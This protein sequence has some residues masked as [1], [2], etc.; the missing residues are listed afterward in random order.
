MNL[1]QISLSDITSNQ[2]NSRQPVPK[3]QRQGY[4]V[5][6][7]V[8]GV[9]KPTLFALAL[10]NQ[11]QKQT[12][13]ALIDAH[14]PDIARMAASLGEDEQLQNIMV[15]PLGDKFALVFGANRCLATLYLHAK[16]NGK[17]AA[18]LW[19]NR[20]EIDQEKA[21]RLSLQENARRRQITYLDEARQC[22]LLAKKGLTHEQIT[23]ELW[24]KHVS[25]ATVANRLKLLK[26]SPKDTDRMVNGEL[27]QESALRI[28]DG[29]PPKQAKNGTPKV[30]GQ[31]EQ[32]N[33]TKTDQDTKDDEPNV[34][35]SDDNPFVFN[36][37]R[38]DEAEALKLMKEHPLHSVTAP[39][40]DAFTKEQREAL[41]R[42]NLVKLASHERMVRNLAAAGILEAD[43]F[44]GFLKMLWAR[45]AEV[46]TVKKGRQVVQVDGPVLLLPE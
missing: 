15:R 19:A 28:V 14:E 32:P 35:P 24:G 42:D 21:W 29:K 39:L 31:K 37:Q 23:E 9:N 34:Q 22:D 38:F 20:K 1:I 10:G 5:V 26:L 36:N 30:L 11:D 7:P 16:S 43:D 46:K 2:D 27:T 12:F 45:K 17:S 4:G 6:E 40:A 25:V 41:I 8:E 3:L 33:Q 44:T 18:T 13:C